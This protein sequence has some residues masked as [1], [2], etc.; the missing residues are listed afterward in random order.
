MGYIYKIV[1]KQTNKTYVG[2]MVQDLD[3]RWKQHKKTNS[4]CRY[5]KSAIKNM[6]L[7]ILI[8]N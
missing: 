1:N 5:L 7:K 6:V 2:Q 8:L 4:N 3:E